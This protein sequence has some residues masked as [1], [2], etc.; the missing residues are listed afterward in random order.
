MRISKVECGGYYPNSERA[1]W[2]L[3]HIN[4]DLEILEIE[5][6]AFPVHFV[7]SKTDGSK[8]GL[9]KREIIKEDQ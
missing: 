1:K 4:D 9:W 6:G 8:C 3:G 7:R 2:I 5:K